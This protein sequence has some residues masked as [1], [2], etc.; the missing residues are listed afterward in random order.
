[1]MKRHILPCLIVLV[2]ALQAGS[3]IP[4][5]SV[6]I[7]E[8]THVPAGYSYWKTGSFKVYSQNPP[9][10]K[11]WFTLP[12]L[13]SSPETVPEKYEDENPW[14][15]GRVFLMSNYN[16]YQSLFN[17]C[18]AMVLVL[19]LALA[20]LLF[21]WA[22]ELYGFT[23]GLIALSFYAFCPNML[24]HSQLATPDVGFCL[25]TA[26][27][28]YWFW[29][30]CK[31]PSWKNIFLSGFTL[32]LA[33]LSKFTALIFYPAFILL[34]IPFCLVERRPL[35]NYV[36]G[37]AIIF[38]LSLLIINSGYLFQEL[39]FPLRSFTLK[40]RLLTVLS[41]SFLGSLPIP[42]PFH[43]IKGF[44]IQMFE[45]EGGQIAFLNGVLSTKGWWYYFIEA[46]CLKTPFP[47]LILIVFRLFIP[48]RKARVQDT[49]FLTIPILTILFQF[50]FLTNINIG[51]RYILPAYPLIFIWLSPF[52]P[53]IASIN[54][55]GN[56]DM[57]RRILSLICVLILL[58][59]SLP[60]LLI[61][62]HHLSYFNFLAGGPEGGYRYLIDSNIDWGQDLSQLKKFMDDRGIP[63][64]YLSYFGEVAPEIYGIS[65]D[66]PPLKEPIHGY[67]AV[68]VSILQG[69]GQWFSTLKGQWIFLPENALTWVKKYTPIGRAG[70]SIYI[71]KF[72]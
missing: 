44:D 68:S 51:L 50:S 26:L 42:L 9:L 43:Y 47:L 49:I 40:S 17:Q 23:A 34:I 62:P 69:K 39:F 3:S 35:K 13:F 20:A 66:L 29:I 5:H 54:T 27:A 22:R 48:V 64:L 36:G 63:R 18:R 8:Y 61:F 56:R 15:Y 71:Y 41:G 72:P 16:A 1:M 45:A 7:D 24:A 65:Y 30:F 58:S 70:Y 12:L 32:G 6:T 2:F 33:Q 4:Q 57:Y 55:I 52:L 38:F 10:I 21:N 11:L 46:F 59:Y 31:D 67:L 14:E 53:S 60:A 25:T 19:S 28:F 37:L